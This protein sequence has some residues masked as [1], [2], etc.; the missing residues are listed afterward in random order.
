MKTLAIMEA[1]SAAIDPHGETRGTAYELM[2]AQL[3]E[4]MRT[5]KKVQSVERKIEAKRSMVGAYD[6]YLSGVLE[7][8]PGSADIVVMTMLVWHLDIGNYAFAAVLAE[9]V[10]RHNMEMPDTY[11]RKTAPLIVEELSDGVIA[12]KVKGS[13]ALTFL[14]VIERLTEGRDMHDQVRAKLHKAIGWAL[15]GRTT[16]HEADL[17]DIP[18]DRALQAIKRL[19]RAIEL[20]PKAGVIKDVERLER[21][22]KD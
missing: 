10:L 11:Q 18:K 16:A 1:A 17:S 22:A 6:A 19:Q 14:Y 4:H 21:I 20:N 13:D 3:H 8:D 15:I 2:Q 12:G 7:A 5:L 9:Y